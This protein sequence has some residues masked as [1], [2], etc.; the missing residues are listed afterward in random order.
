M[1]EGRHRAVIEAVEPEVDCGRFPIKRAVGETVRVEADIFTDG[2][3]AIGAVL[4]HR[5]DG[6]RRWRE[7]PM[8][9]LI[10][11]RW[12][13]EFTVGELGRYSYTLLAWVDH[14]A[15]WRTGF[16]KK[17]EAAQDVS[18]DVLVGADLLEEA[19][20]RASG[21]SAKRLSAWATELRN[22]E[23]P[24]QRARLALDDE[25]AELASRYSD[26]S[27]ATSYGRQ[28]EVVVDREEAR[29]GAWY[30][31]FPRSYG[32]AGAH[33]TFRDLL[34]HLPY[35]AGM[36]FDVLYLPPIHPIGR[37]HRKGA[38]NALVARQG[39]P[40]VPWAIGSEEGGHKAVHSELGTMEDFG[41]LVRRAEE[42]GMQVA[43]DIA[44]QC[45]PDHPYVD[46]SPQWFRRRPDGTIQYAEN[47]PKKYEDIYPFDFE[48]EDWQALWHEL[49][50]VFSFW[51]GQGVHIFRVD[52]PHTK[53]FAFWE[54]AIG[55]LKR[56]HPE[57]IFLSE[58]FTRPKV[59]YRLAKLGFTQSYTY[60]T[61]RNTKA[62][63]TQYFSELTQTSVR[64]YFRPNLWPNTP[65]ILNEYLQ[66]GGRPAF[67]ARLVLAATLSANY[68]VY[69]PAFELMENIPRQPGS[70]EYLHSEK[71][72]IKQWDIDRPDSL[73]PLL[74][75]INHIR[76]HNPALQAD[77][78]LRFHPID[79][80]QLICYSKQEGTNVIVVVVN[81]D[82]HHVQPGWLELPLEELD[83]DPSQPYQ[84]QDLLAETRYIWD[85]P[86]NY[87][88][89]DPAV[90]PAHIF[91]VRRRTRTEADFDYYM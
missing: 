59:M 39:D 13:G 28:L 21:A 4:L 2:H 5:R 6:E 66:V 61:W 51:L 86:R 16:R 12:W 74:A 72:E 54:W 32:P 49:R 26:R 44:F 7:T 81:L 1:K 55:E 34:D 65:D 23:G 76:R 63:L 79:N 68:G 77:W 60:F 11:D 82:P 31:L 53:P 9:P 50:E 19:A 87:V 37:T 69:G 57:A 90:V 33:G 48:T 40:G 22:G 35:V 71:Y 62:E 80:E 42:L 46:K 67:I 24:R 75:R 91:L 45:S 18:V 17:V 47:P 15:T 88:E 36:G 3:D 84:V 25:L 83:I 78:S 85:G 38:N 70:E 73:A 20:R 27:L 41:R 52:N 30:E 8:E 58:A 29:F 10:N 64:E 43:L 89:L 56:D 14:F